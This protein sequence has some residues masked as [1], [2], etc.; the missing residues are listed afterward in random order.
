VSSGRRATILAGVL[1]LGSGFLFVRFFWWGYRS[2]QC[3]EKPCDSVRRKHFPFR[4]WN[5]SGIP[6][7]EGGFIPDPHYLWSESLTFSVPA[8]RMLSA[9][10]SRYAIM[11]VNPAFDDSTSEVLLL[12]QSRDTTFEYSLTFPRHKGVQAISAYP[13]PPPAMAFP[14]EHGLALLANFF[15]PAKGIYILPVPLRSGATL[16]LIPANSAAFAVV[17][18]TFRSVGAERTTRDQFCESKRK[19]FIAFYEKYYGPC[20]GESRIVNEVD[21]EFT[22]F[23]LRD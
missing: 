23:W 16:A 9:E 11:D 13:M 1:V 12:I 15:G 22:S 19:D 2:P 14:Y 21:K 3:G 18:A 6:L 20:N 10:D 8:S 17:A 7:L 5:W 4:H